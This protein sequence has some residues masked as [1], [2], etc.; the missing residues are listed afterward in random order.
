MFNTIKLR[1]LLETLSSMII[2]P[3]IVEKLWALL[4]VCHYK[5]ETTHCQAPVEALQW[6]PHPIIVNPPCDHDHSCAVITMDGI[7]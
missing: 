5:Y 3:L 6:E 7:D 1:N 4:Q 2:P